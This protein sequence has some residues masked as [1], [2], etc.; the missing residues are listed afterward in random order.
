MANVYW[1]GVAAGISVGIGL[2]LAGVLGG[3]R[4]GVVLALVA[5]AL[6]VGVGLLIGEW[7]EAVGGAVGGLAGGFGGERIVGG[8]LRRGGT[9]G[10]TSLLVG[11]A[12][13][14][15]AVLA[16]VPLVGYVESVALPAL[17]ARL[18]RHTG[19]RFAGLRIL[20]RDE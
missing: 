10:A 14:L 9:R 17:G 7:D 20:A 16:F 3:A 15:L 1:I 5:A 19:E 4:L 18:R 11:A 12:A 8:T 6:G 13:L 2:L